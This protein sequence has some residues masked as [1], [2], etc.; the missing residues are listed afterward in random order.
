METEKE[1]E[2]RQAHKALL[3]VSEPLLVNQ[4]GLAE[5]VTVTRF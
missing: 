4:A 3:P 5:S 2:K 1:K